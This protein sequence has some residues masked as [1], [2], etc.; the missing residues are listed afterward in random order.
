VSNF[1]SLLRLVSAF[2]KGVHY[3]VLTLRNRLYKYFK[4][5]AV[6]LIFLLQKL[7][8]SGDS[9]TK[10]GELYVLEVV[11]LVA[12]VLNGYRHVGRN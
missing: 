3:S 5:L 8:A 2:L 6:R 11:R 1:K 7:K 4:G 10:Y 12:C 9:V